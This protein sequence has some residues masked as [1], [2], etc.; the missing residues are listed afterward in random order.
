MQFEIGMAQ[1]QHQLG[2]QAADAQMGRDQQLA[3][4]MAKLQ[5][6][7]TKAQG[8]QDRKTN[9][10]QSQNNMNEA[11]F[12]NIL[13][14]GNM[15]LEGQIEQ[16][17]MTHGAGLD[18]QK[19]Q[20]A[21]G[22]QMQ[23]DEASN[24]HKKDFLTHQTDEKLRY[25][26]AERALPPSRQEKY[27]ADVMRQEY[28][29][30]IRL[31]TLEAANQKEV[32]SETT[33]REDKRV[34]AELEIKRREMDLKQKELDWKMAQASGETGQSTTYPRY[35]STGPQPQASK[36]NKSKSRKQRERQQGGGI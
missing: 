34:D 21:H 12:N 31:D 27:A 20:Q 19:S 28:D 26:E 8:K 32:R 22:F 13:K 9:A 16:D 3:T 30:K 10:A 1:Y 4:H 23:R 7:Q 15:R 18:M 29:R 17:R 5:K 24:D 14:Q 25:E 36:V 33:R 11:S 2:Q 6:K 35:G